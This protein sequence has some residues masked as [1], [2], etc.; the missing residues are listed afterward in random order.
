MAKP[1]ITLCCFPKGTQSGSAPRKAMK[2]GVVVP[3]NDFV[4]AV[5]PSG[6]DGTVWGTDGTMNG[7]PDISGNPTPT[8]IDL[9]GVAVL[10]AV[11]ADPSIVTVSTTGMNFKET[12]V[13]PGTGVAVTFTVTFNPVPTG[14]VPGPFKAVDTVDVKL[15]PPGPVTA[16]LIIHSTPTM[17]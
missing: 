9:T 12:G 4:L 6:A 10:S 2:A 17:V 14:S 7:P 3:P 15:P 8:Q 13:K 16:L 5:G 1:T 11:S